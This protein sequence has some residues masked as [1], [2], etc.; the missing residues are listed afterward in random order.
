MLGFL[1]DDKE[2]VELKYLLQ[3]EL[4]EMLLDL[5]DKRIDKMVRNAIEDRYKVIFRMYGR[6][7][8]SQEMSR[9]CRYS[10]TSK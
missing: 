6:L 5:N 9:Y 2:C 10:L 8:S 4:E 1:F 7:A 3:K